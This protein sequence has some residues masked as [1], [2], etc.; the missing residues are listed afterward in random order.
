MWCQCVHRLDTE[1]YIT[2]M[3]ERMISEDILQRNLLHPVERIC[4]VV[5]FAASQTDQQ[6]V[7]AKIDVFR[8]HIRVHAN[9]FNGQTLAN[10][11]SLNLHSLTDDICHLILIKLILQQPVRQSAMWPLSIDKRVRTYANVR[12]SLLMAN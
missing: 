5:V 7:S 11:L 3:L 4:C 9:E 10:E 1:R 8:H 2:R 12:S 6:A